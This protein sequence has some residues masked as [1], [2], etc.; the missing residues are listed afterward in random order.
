MLKTHFL[1]ERRV[2]LWNLPH[3]LTP[4]QN[5]NYAEITGHKSA[6]TS[7]RWLNNG[8]IAS[9]SADTTVGIWDTETGQRIR[10]FAAHSLV[11]NEVD[12]DQSL[13]AS[14]GDDGIAF[15]WDEREKSYI[16]NFKTDYPLLSVAFHNNILFASGIEPIIRAWDIRSPMTPL[17]EIETQHTDSITSLSIDDNNLISKDDQTIRIY[18]PKIVPG[19]HI[20][21]KIYDGAPAGTENLLIRSV[22]KDNL[23]I[24][25]SGDKTVTAWDMTSGRLL[26]KLTGHTGTVIDVDEHNGKIASSSV[27]GT[28][29]LRY[30]NGISGI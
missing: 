16:N 30:T 4:G 29:I 11:V 3:V 17:Y 27:D 20:R 22:I 1:P 15:V 6:V 12:N 13:V 25:G 2:L 23:I 18:D 7:T 9:S 21:P 24:S 26:R 8:N 19:T 14:V 5:P 28:V 10:K